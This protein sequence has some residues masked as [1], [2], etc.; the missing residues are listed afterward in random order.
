[1]STVRENLLALHN[2]KRAAA[3]LVALKLDSVLNQGADRY[4]EIM[5][6]NNWFSHTRPSGL[7]WD[8]WWDQYYPEDYDYPLRGIGENIA[9]GQTTTSQV[10]ADWWAS[11]DHRDNIMGRAFRRVGFGLQASASGVNYWVAHYCTKP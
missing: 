7:T 3:G 8:Q 6:A 2:Q 9:R 5:A 11:S 1:M 4:A 10:F